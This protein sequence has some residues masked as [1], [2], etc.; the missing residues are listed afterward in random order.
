MSFETAFW[1]LVMRD[2]PDRAA[3]CEGVRVLATYIMQYLVRYFRRLPD[4]IRKGVVQDVLI[5]IQEKGRTARCPKGFARMWAM[6]KALKAL[7]ELKKTGSGFEPPERSCEDDADLAWEEAFEGLQECLRELP[8]DELRVIEAQYLKNPATVRELARELDKPPST[9]SDM[10]QRALEDLRRC[11]ER[12][13]IN[14]N[15]LRD[16]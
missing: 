12:K 16:D 3:E 9:I 11:L 10:K 8:D 2:F 5:V 7:D 13:G 1:H 15:W 4:D 14:L 6:S